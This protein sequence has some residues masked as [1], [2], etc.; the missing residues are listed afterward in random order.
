M[1]HETES[2]TGKVW[3]Q[4]EGVGSCSENSGVNPGGS[5]SS[6]NTSMS[7]AHTEGRGRRAI[8]IRS[9]RT[10]QG[11]GPVANRRAW[12]LGLSCSSPLRACI[13]LEQGTE[14]KQFWFA[15]SEAKIWIGDGES[16]DALPFSWLIAA[17]ERICDGET[18]R[19][20]NSYI[21]ASVRGLDRCQI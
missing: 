12:S 19:V 16:L 9:K 3:A 5:S 18:I 6:P 10:M 11:E 13:I 2:R 7:L 15:R 1:S 8:L 21:W 4:R 17:W 20:E 14:L